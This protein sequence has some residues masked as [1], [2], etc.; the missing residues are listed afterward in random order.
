MTSF[1]SYGSFVDGIHHSVIEEN[2]LKRESKAAEIEA[3]ASAAEKERQ[4]W[5]DF[6]QE[7]N[8]KCLKKLGKSILRNHLEGF[9]ACYINFER[10]HFFRREFVAA[11]TYDKYIASNVLSRWLK[12]LRDETD[13]FKEL[14]KSVSTDDTLGLDTS[15]KIVINFD[16]WNNAKFTVHI[17]WKS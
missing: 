10:R 16:V 15:T 1:P 11:K 13:F 4:E 9:R 3:T 8:K 12:T 6:V 14:L 2:R 5:Q 7:T 17:T